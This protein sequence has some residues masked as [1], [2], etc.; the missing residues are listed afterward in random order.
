MPVFLLLY[1]AALA[2]AWAA[3]PWPVRGL[4][5][6]AP[7]P[8]DM[9]LCLRFIRD[10]LPKEGVNTLVME[11]GYGYQFTRRPELADPRGLSKA[12]VQAIAEACKKAGVRFIPQIDLLGHQSWAKTTHALLRAHPEFDETP[13][14]YPNNEGIYCR[15]YCPLH[16]NVHDVV[17]DLIDEL[18][19]AAGADAFHAGM[20]EVFLIGE[21]SCPRCK[22]KDKAELFAGEVS[23]IH[24]HLAKTGRKLWIWGDRL[25][26]GE[27]TGIGK[28]DA[29]QNGTHAAIGKIP[30]DVVI[31]DWH[32]HRALPTAAYFA[33]Q[34]F[35]VVS[36]PWREADVALAQLEQIEAVRAQATGAIAGRMQGVLQT[37]WCGFGPF[38][39][40]YFG[41]RPAEP[42]VA[43]VE[44]AA[45]FK[46]LFRQIRQRKLN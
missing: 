37:T 5:V 23:A 39:R 28:W 38:A 13:G 20:D 43:A 19:E 6:S 32:Y 22:G 45:C 44:A 15:S 25:L 33:V 18:A 8:E 10:A 40:A 46:A 7:R 42:N 3:E 14:Q 12:D 16:P 21:D 4:H 11:F 29:S 24:D 2:P 34:G 26:D 31:C 35:P 30:K 36:S 27:L 1:L 17:F 41:E 9:P